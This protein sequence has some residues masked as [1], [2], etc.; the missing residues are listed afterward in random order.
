MRPLPLRP[1]NPTNVVTVPAGL[2]R[3]IASHERYVSDTPIY[4]GAVDQAMAPS[5]NALS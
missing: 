4:L 1:T 5:S 2:S 3:H